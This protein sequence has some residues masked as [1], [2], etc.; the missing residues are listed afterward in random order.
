MK[1]PGSLSEIEKALYDLT[2]R[3]RRASLAQWRGAAGAVA[4][5]ELY[6]QAGTLVSPRTLEILDAGPA[7]SRT[8]RLRYNL[9]DHF[10]QR[11]LLASDVELKTWVSGAAA[12]VDG[13]NI[14]FRQ[15]IPWCQK[16]ST[17]AQRQVLQKETRALCRFLTPFARQYWVSLLEILER[18]FGYD[19]YIEYCRQKKIIDYTAWHGRV[20]KMLADT[21]GFYFDAM[22]GWCRERF[23]IPLQEATRFDAINLLAMVQYDRHFPN[24]PLLELTRFFQAWE[25]DIDDIPA[26]RI[27]LLPEDARTAQAMCFVLQTPERIHILMRP[28]GGWIDLETLFHELGHGLSAAFTSAALSVTQ[29]EMATCFS[30]SES[31]AFL[32]QNLALSTPLLTE[33]MGIE[34]GLATEISRRR[35]LRNLSLFRR[36]AARFLAEYEMFSRHD[37]SSGEV[38]ADLMRRHTGFYY[39]PDSFLFDLVP[40]FYSLDYLRAWMVEA[41]LDAHLRKETGDPWLFS[42]EAGDVLRGWWSQGNHWE[43]DVFLEKNQLPPT[44]TERLAKRWQTLEDR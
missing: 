7:D 36:Y 6:S 22:D 37:F 9:I 44:G 26:I 17:R 1:T 30:L 10:L 28:Q 39:Q 33:F 18:N 32:L 12:Q 24:R 38:Y 4:M 34:K 13:Q 27:E 43:M 31:W 29:R 35:Q 5:S 16:Q 21:E 25:I 41:S 2:L 15:I 23:D 11:E 19:D 3:W 40:E 8:H 20:E 42:K 14:Y